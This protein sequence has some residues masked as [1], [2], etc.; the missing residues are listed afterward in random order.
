MRRETYSI[1]IEYLFDSARKGAKYTFNKGES[2]VNGGEAIEIFVKSALGLSA[3]KDANTPFDVDSDIPGY[4]AS[5]KSSA[6]TLTS[7]KLGETFEEVKA[8]YFRRTVSTCTVY[9]YIT[10]DTLVTYWMTMEEFAE[11]LDT[12][13]VWEASR[14]VIRGKKLSG[15]MIEWFEARVA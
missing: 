6:F 11:Y 4:H 3:E 8:E 5:V 12:F 9:G 7:E 13:G 14:K 10:E 1:N 2:W 15:K